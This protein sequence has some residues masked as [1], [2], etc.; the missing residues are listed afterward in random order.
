[1]DVPPELCI[2]LESVV[3]DVVQAFDEAV[4]AFHLLGLAVVFFQRL[5]ILSGCEKDNTRTQSR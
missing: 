3:H 5:T 1:M 4:E 2:N